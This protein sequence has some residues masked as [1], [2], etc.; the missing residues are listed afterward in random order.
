MRVAEAVVRYEEP[1]KKCSL[2]TSVF[3][4]L[5]T[6]KADRWLPMLF[7]RVLVMLEGDNGAFY[8]PFGGI[9]SEYL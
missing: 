3:S 8:G 4:Q 9:F 2:S 6:I 5:I 7:W 1:K